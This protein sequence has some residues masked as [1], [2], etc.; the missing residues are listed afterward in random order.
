MPNAAGQSLEEPHMRAR[1]CQLDMAEALTADFRQRDFH[2][3][4]IADHPAVLHALVLAA[5]ALP[6][7]DRP[8]NAG[9][10]QAVAFRLEG[11][12]VDRLRFRH[13]AM[14][15]APDFLRRGQADADS[16]EIGNR[17][18]QVKWART[19]QDFLHSCGHFAA[20]S[21]SD[22]QSRSWRRRHFGL[23]APEHLL[24]V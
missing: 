21:G 15:P 20:A 7:G 8:K 23:A 12:I 19:E 2:A 6:V 9:A 18:C 10:E 1:R 22:L 5:E 17:I 14:R 11:A 16:V 3:A 4:L 24:P 13:L